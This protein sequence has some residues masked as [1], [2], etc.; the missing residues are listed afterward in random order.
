M[1]TASSERMKATDAPFSCFYNAAGKFIGFAHGLKREILPA[2]YSSLANAID[3]NG[4]PAQQLAAVS[5]LPDS[6]DNSAANC[7]IANY[8]CF[9]Y[10]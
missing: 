9:Y 10:Q 2:S 7:Q 4:T 5:Q 1:A 3:P 6:D 8:T